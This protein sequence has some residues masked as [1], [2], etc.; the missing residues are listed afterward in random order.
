MILYLRRQ[1]GHDEVIHTSWYG[2]QVTINILERTV[3]DNKQSSPPATINVSQFHSYLDQIG[4]FVLQYGEQQ[5]AQRAARRAEKR[6]Q[7]AQQEAERQVA[8]LPAGQRPRTR[9][10]AQAR[11][12]EARDAIFGRSAAASP[13]NRTAGAPHHILPLIPQLNLTQSAISRYHKG[14]VITKVW[15]APLHLWST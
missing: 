1:K 3:K 6:T 13:A 10:A 8:A 7:K 9:Q 14:L 11:Q 5:R 2:M 15:S 12:T 4:A